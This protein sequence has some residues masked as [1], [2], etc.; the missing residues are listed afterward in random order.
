MLSAYSVYSMQCCCPAHEKTNGGYINVF[1]LSL[2]WVLIGFLIGMLANGARLW[3]ASW[4][5]RRWLYLPTVGM[6]LALLGG[7][8]GTFLQGTLFATATAIWLTAAGVVMVAWLG[9]YFRR[10]GRKG[11]YL[12]L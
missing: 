6:L 1:M 9:K 7:W 4:E 5:R 8:L 3:P 10:R 12:S 11:Q 2:L